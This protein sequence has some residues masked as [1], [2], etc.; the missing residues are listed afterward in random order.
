[1]SAP[2]NADL[3]A[4]LQACAR[5][6]AMVGDEGRAH[7]FAKAARSVAVYPDPLHLRPSLRG[8]P[9]VG[10]AVGTTLREVLARGTSAR[11]EQLQA[12]GGPE[13]EA[14][15]V[16]SERLGPV[17]AW[18]LCQAHGLGTLA[19]VHDRVSRGDL[20]D[21]RLFDLPA[22]AS[23]VV[24][25]TLA[26]VVPQGWTRHGDLHT[27]TALSDGQG[28]MLELVR[29]AQA[30]GLRWLGVSDHATGMRPRGIGI[31]AIEAYRAVVDA[32]ADETGFSV[33]LGLE[34]DVSP[35][36]MP[37]VSSAVLAEVD[38]VIAAVHAPSLLPLPERFRAILATGKVRALGHPA[39]TLAAPGGQRAGFRDWEE[40]CRQCAS[41]GVAVE[42]GGGRHPLLSP[43]HVRAALDAGC[44]LSAASDTHQGA[45]GLVQ[46]GAAYGLLERLGLPE[47]VLLEHRGSVG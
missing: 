17:D 41:L 8:V 46:L 10:E 6:Y 14:F 9:F 43:D 1:M 28:T 47:T 2:T 3:A 11:L 44:A 33:R 35:S 4:H 37:L 32:A 45:A 25:R 38:Y 13:P 39:D 21:A 29:G 36:G 5:R 19:D 30:L 12:T 24:P 7:A 40:L 26:D 23:A 15:L 18:K 27:H 34:V 42:V 31:D 20:P 16:L 22:K